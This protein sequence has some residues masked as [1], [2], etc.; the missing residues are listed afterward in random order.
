MNAF[1][2]I[3]QAGVV[4]KGVLLILLLFSLA[5]WMIIF[6]KLRAF[7]QADRQDERFLKAFRDAK[8]LSATYEESRRFPRS[9][10]AALYREGYREL[11]LGL[12][13]TPANPGTSAEAVKP[14]EVAPDDLVARI[15]RGLRHASLREIS[16]LERSL[17]FLATTGNITPFIGLFGT[18]WGIM[19]AFHGI[20]VTGSANLGTVAPGIAEAL[21]TTAAGLAVAIPGVIAYNYFLNRIK[22]AATRM[23]L[24][25]LEFVGTAERIILRTG[26][27]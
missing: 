25:G 21:I 6:L 23:D 18:V 11:S 9:P 22:R 4:A 24:F 26:R 5:S 13:G 16:G 2:L 10:L 1:N 3:L 8:Q 17:I 15:S 12:K 20:G 19:D 27:A 7:S 14:S